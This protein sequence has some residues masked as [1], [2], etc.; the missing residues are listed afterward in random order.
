MSHN[1]PGLVTARQKG[2]VLHRTTRPLPMLAGTQVEQLDAWQ[3]EWVGGREEAVRLP[4]PCYH[5][6][7]WCRDNVVL[8]DSDV[9]GRFGGF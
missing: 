5:F 8:H 3:S 6:A 1:T 7:R 2:L 4:M 9:R